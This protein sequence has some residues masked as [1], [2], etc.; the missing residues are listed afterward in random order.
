MGWPH[1]EVSSFDPGFIGHNIPYGNHGS[2]KCEACPFFRK[3]SK[4]ASRGSLKR[5][6][7]QIVCGA[8][9]SS[10]SLKLLF[11][12]D[13]WIS[14]PTARDAT[15]QLGF[16]RVVF[17]QAPFLHRPSAKAFRAKQRK[18][19]VNKHKMWSLTQGKEKFP[20]HPHFS[21]LVVAETATVSPNLLI[22]R[23]K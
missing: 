4:R 22:L 10:P 16:S 19:P 3:C 8:K 13:A 17:A 23:M 12:V 9:C 11:W 18:F 15:A 1:C 5:R 14:P 6:K 7:M 21:N 2:H 20:W